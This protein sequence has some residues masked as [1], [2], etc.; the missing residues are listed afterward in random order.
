MDAPPSNAPPTCTSI[1]YY[2]VAKIHHH[3]TLLVLQTLLQYYNTT[4]SKPLAQLPQQSPTSRRI[5]LHQTHRQ[6]HQPPP[7]SSK[8]HRF[9][10]PQEPLLLVNYSRNRH[11]TFKSL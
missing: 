2:L 10:P 11:Y 6:K 8:D 7:A 9:A 3:H 5:R 1:A 4:T